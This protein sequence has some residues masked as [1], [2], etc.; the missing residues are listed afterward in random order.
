MITRQ[1][2]NTTI[3]SNMQQSSINLAKVLIASKP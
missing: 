2:T 1:G 3:S